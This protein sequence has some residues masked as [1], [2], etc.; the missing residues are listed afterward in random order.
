[1]TTGRTGSFL[2]KGIS[3][4]FRLNRNTNGISTSEGFY[5]SVS[6]AVAYIQ[7]RWTIRG[8][9]EDTTN[10]VAESIYNILLT[11]EKEWSNLP[12]YGSRT[13]L[14]IFEPNTVEFQLLFSSY[15]KFS[16]ERWDK[17]AKYPE[18][19]VQWYPTGLQTDRG[20]LPV[21]ASIEYA[22]QQHPKN[23]VT[24]FVTVRQ[25]RVQEYPASVIDD[26]GHDLISRYYKRTAYYNNDLKYLRILR[27][28]NIPPA[29]DDIFYMIKP[30][31]TWML[32]SYALLGEVRYWFYP[33]LCYI[34]DKAIEGGTRDILNPNNFPETGTLLRVPSKERIL[35]IN[36]RR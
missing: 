17:R 34:Q 24:P 3:W 15:L 11:H 8:D 32:I 4:P 28:I 18:N 5:D 14:A 31:D 1:M 2:G 26:N 16:T 13:A 7:E 36:T 35:L 6:V 22:T 25:V 19:G 27:N 30:A 33:Y 12:W 29:P 21:V 9:V 23:L 20:E 10:H